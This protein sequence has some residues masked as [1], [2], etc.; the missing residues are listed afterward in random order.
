VG[1]RRLL[2]AA[3]LAVVAAAAL[4]LGAPA[5]SS[6]YLEFKLPSGNIGCGY[7]KFEG[8][9]ASLR[10]EIVSGLR[11]LPPKPRRCDGDWGRAVGMAPTGSASRYCITDTVMNPGAPVLA[12]GRTWSRG[13]FVCR[14]R[15]DGLTCT[16]RSGHGWFLSR[17]R[18]RLL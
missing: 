13:G 2:I 9:T 10:C 15:T 11:P 12:Y 18:S 5:K 3:V 16:N 8:E 17:A 6:V 4:P 14:S 1:S 7:A